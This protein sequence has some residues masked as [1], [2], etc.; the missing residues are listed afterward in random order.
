MPGYAD[1]LDGL[2][3]FDFIWV[4]SV[5]HRN[6]GFKKKIRPQPRADA[7][8]Q[9][10]PL[11]GLFCS[12]AP[13]R[14]NPLA[15]SALKV[16]GVDV[17]A[18]V[19]EV[20]G[21]DLLDGTPVLDIKPYVPAFDAF[22][23]ARAGWMDAIDGGDYLTSR[24]VGYQEIKSPRGARATRAAERKRQAAGGSQEGEE[25]EETVADGGREGPPSGP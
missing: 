24:A 2:A 22:P 8:G 3:G 1:C 23:D 11:V 17:A 10:P 6:S 18:G 9:P 12:R 16:T 5:M 4:I 25:A 19:I 7:A 20:I 15:L 21:L 14:P 13:H